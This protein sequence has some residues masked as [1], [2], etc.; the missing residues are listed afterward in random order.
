MEDGHSALNRQNDVVRKNIEELDDIKQ[1]SDNLS[2]LL[3]SIQN[4]ELMN[5]AILYLLV[6]V[7]TL[8]NLMILYFKIIK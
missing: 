1:K 5:K 6:V 2:K 4:K 3:K 7:L 8:A